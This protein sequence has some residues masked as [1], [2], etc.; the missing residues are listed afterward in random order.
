MD[1]E[2]VWNP[3]ELWPEA[4]PPL[5]GW[6]R[7]EKGRWNEPAPLA[8]PPLPAEIAAHQPEVDERLE[9]GYIEYEPTGH[10]T[11]AASGVEPVR[12]LSAA[13]LAAGIALVLIIILLLIT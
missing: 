12:A 7:D 11:E 9:L 2:G 3:P 6:T 13:A 1:V 8:P 5:P 10:E 4:S